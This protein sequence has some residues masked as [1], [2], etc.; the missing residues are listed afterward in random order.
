M[1]AERLLARREYAANAILEDA[2]LRGDLTDE[3]YTPIQAEALEYVD[4]KALGTEGLDEDAAR[5]A[6]DAAVADAKSRIRA[7]TSQPATPSPAPTNPFSGFLRR[8]RLRL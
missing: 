1:S 2:R 3:E 4:Q 5:Q 8:L 6:I 7:R